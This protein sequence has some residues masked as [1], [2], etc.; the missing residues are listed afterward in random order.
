MIVIT[1]LIIFK[2]SKQSFTPKLTYLSKQHQRLPKQKAHSVSQ[3]QYH[4]ESRKNLEIT[5]IL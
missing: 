5:E 4:P 3:K 2:G 1:T